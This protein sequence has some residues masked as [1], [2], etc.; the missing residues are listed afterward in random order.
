MD[1]FGVS[2]GEASTWRSIVVLITYLGVKLDPDQQEAIAGA[3]VALFTL[4]G[5]FFKRDLVEK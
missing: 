2:F 1:R 4:L 5:V 3:G